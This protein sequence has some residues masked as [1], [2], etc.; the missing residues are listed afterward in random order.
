MGVKRAETRGWAFP[1]SYTW[2]SS[3][4]VESSVVVNQNRITWNDCMRVPCSPLGPISGP[5][6]FV[7]VHVP[8]WCRCRPGASWRGRLAGLGNPHAKLPF[9]GLELAR[10]GKGRL[11]V[12]LQGFDTGRWPDGSG[13][14]A[15][16]RPRPAANKS[17]IGLG[18]VIYL[19]RFFSPMTDS[20]IFENLRQSVLSSSV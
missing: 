6:R 11:L 3:P 12:R 13:E 17:A 15:N 14:G 8:T 1:T 4:G 2:H 20:P 18:C 10:G 9:L 16:H 19:I 7:L 5:P